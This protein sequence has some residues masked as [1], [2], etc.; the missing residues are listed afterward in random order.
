MYFKQLIYLLLLLITNSAIAKGLDDANVNSIVEQATWVISGRVLDVNEQPLPGATVLIKGTNLGTA[1]NI[2]GDYTLSVPQKPG[3]IV[4]TFIG[5]KSR[6]L[7]YSSSGV[8]N[9]ILDES[10]DAL[11]EIVVIGYGAVE[12]KDL[13]GSVG[14]VNVDDLSLAPVSSFTEALAGRVAGVQVS[15]GDGQPGSS[16][17]I[18]IRGSGSITQSNSPLYV[19]DGI[20]VE[21][22][23]AS[24]LNTND[25]ESLTILKD[26]SSTAIYGARGA[27]G[28]VVIETKKGIVGKPIVSI[29]SS[30]GFQNITKQMDVM[31]PYEFVKYQTELNLA[32][33]TNFYLSDGKTLESYKE[34]TG[35]NWQDEVF[36]TGLTQIHD[37]SL[38]GGVNETRYSASFSNYDQEAVIINTGFSRYQGR[39][40]LD[41]KINKKLKAGFIVNY[42]E[43]T[44][45][46]I[47]ASEGTND[48]SNYLF[49][50]TWGYRPVSGNGVDLLTEEVDEDVITAND[51][52]IN[53]VLTAENA[54][55]KSIINNFSAQLYTQ[56]DISKDLML[57]ITAGTSSRK[58]RSE[59]F[60]NSKTPRGSANSPINSRGVNGGIY[61]SGIRNLTNENILT[62]KKT[63]NRYHRLNVLFG[64]SA[65]SR[66]TD[67]YGYGTQLLPNETLG[68]PGLDEGVPSNTVAEES[69]FTLMSFFNRLNYNYKSKYLFTATFR[70]DGS[71]KF[72]VDNRWGF[73]PSAA[74]A[75]NMNKEK[76]MRPLKFVSNSKLRISYGLTGNNRVGDF[77]YLPGLEVPAN[78]TVSFDNATPY[79]TV[80]F[81]NLG[82]SNLKWETTKQLDIG[83]DLG[84]FNDRIEL[85]ADIYRKTTD[86][87]LLNAQL[88]FTT[89]FSSAYKN[90]GK[91]KN[92][93]LELGVFSKNIQTESFTWES[94]FNISFNK[95]EVL[96]LAEGQNKLFS[97]PVF[98]T[99]YDNSPLWVAEVGKPVASFHGYV[100]DGIYQFEDFDN[101]SPDAYVLK[102]TITTNGNPR[103]NIQPGD[104]KYK[105]LNKDGVVN[106]LDQTILGRATP[107]HFGGF[108]NNFSYKGFLL[109]IFLQWSYGNKIY[110]ANRLLLDGNAMLRRNL[111][112]YATYEN[113]WTPESPSNEYFRTGGQG[114]FG[115][116]SSR[117]LED[118]SY[119]R[120]KTVSIGYQIPTNFIKKFHLNSLTLQV[121]AQNLLTLTNYSGMDPEVSV[122]NSALTPGFDYSAYPS[123]QTFVFS[124]KG[125]F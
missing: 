69:K 114:P 60:Y 85:T 25:I 40:S 86:D 64:F 61:F 68:I 35:I 125:S 54:H 23:D 101:P 91:I 62:Y 8:Y 34:E 74:F 10:S 42:A 18:V 73:F 20:P 21:S 29:N 89:G 112:Q 41:Q 27:N 87:L 32:D 120:F 37:I 15:S 33:A 115:Y 24:S 95:N 94:S 80:I 90:I 16:Q 38:R 3:V 50:N 83:Y 17:S 2:N 109:N 31:S 104:I 7:P 96:S 26:A 4:V 30:L 99:Y 57:K 19:I 12:K 98:A 6:E 47:P 118:G 113:R 116:H 1:T 59:A 93:G 117:V 58:T 124:L 9:F 81:D 51:I 66:I 11:S 97:N 65:Q 105:D 44:K 56:Y 106:S 108:N 77:S 100:F 111:N 82:N 36:R 5:F 121:S 79:N 13:T 70:S 52:R 103:E 45:F 71:S 48:V 76:F 123:A 49:Y 122:R 107:I 84:L 92:E 67:R 75:W 102:N 63:I 39:I 53:P 55:N 43:S 28:V 119:L 88:P 72:A 46:G 14:Q 110:N 78:V 22:F